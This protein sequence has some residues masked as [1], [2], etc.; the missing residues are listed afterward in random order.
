MAIDSLYHIGVDVRGTNSN[1]CVQVRRRGP[2]AH[3]EIALTLSFRGGARHHQGELLNLV[4]NRDTLGGRH[5]WL[6][7]ACRHGVDA[8]HDF[9]RLWLPDHTHLVAFFALDFGLAIAKVLERVR[10]QAGQLRSATHI[11]GERRL[12]NG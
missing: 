1:E 6:V 8:D 3:L 10:G 9:R 11:G 12:G 4:I 7:R 2:G 5:L